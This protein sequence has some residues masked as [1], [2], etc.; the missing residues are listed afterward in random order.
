VS[1]ARDAAHQALSGGRTYLER[2]GSETSLRARKLTGSLLVVMAIATPAARAQEDGPAAERKAAALRLFSDGLADVDA[3]RWAP[4]ADR[5]GRAY[6]LRPTPEI[7]YNLASAD[8]HL[9]RLT[10]A[11]RLL[12]RVADDP[13]ARTGVR[14]AA[15]ARLAELGP[16]LPRLSVAAP[17]AQAEHLWLDGAPLGSPA[18]SAIPLDPGS[19]LVE[20]R[21]PDGET[22]SRTVVLAEGER[23]ALTFAAPPIPAAVVSPPPVRPPP[24][25]SILRRGWF[26]G[27][28]G[29]VAAASLATALLVSRTGPAEVRGNVDTWDLRH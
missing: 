22:L 2:R 24:A 8:A 26:W 4:A 10:E 12:G 23:H 16:R 7:A 3:Q 17:P 21:L 29:G 28:V 6:A 15:R 1:G 19:H 27:V 11:S 5:F 20:L 25:P 18:G 14:E 9:G 13:Q